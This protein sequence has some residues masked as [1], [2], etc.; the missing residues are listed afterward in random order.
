VW[1][2]VAWVRVYVCLRA[3]V[4]VVQITSVLPKIIKTSF[5][6]VHLHYFFTAGPD[7][8]RGWCIRKGYKAPQVRPHSFTPWPA[9]CCNCTQIFEHDSL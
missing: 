7:E 1:L 2:G 5:S 9:P 6:M 3:R 4:G 8:V